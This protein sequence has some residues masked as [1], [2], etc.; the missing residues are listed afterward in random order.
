MRAVVQRGY[1]SSQVWSLDDVEV[2]VPGRGEVLVEVAAAAVDRGTW[3]LMHG[4]PAMVRPVIG[5]RT[6][7]QPV[8][9][10][11]VAGTVTAVG[12]GVTELAVGD[13]VFGMARGSLAP[14]A[15]AKVA[16][17][18]PRP[19]GAPWAEAAAL[20]VSGLTAWQALEAAQVGGGGRLL[21]VGA[22]GGVG[23]LAVQLAV[24]RGLEVVAV[25]SRAKAESVR[26]WGATRVLAHDAA[27]DPHA[28]VA[29]A[30]TGF[31]ALLDVAG[32]LPLATQRRLVTE[33]GTMVFV[34]TET[35]QRITGGFGA[36]VRRSLRMALARQRYVM[37]VSAERGEDL[38]RLAEAYEAG[39]VR[40]HLH[41]VL[42]L[43]QAR[44]AIDLLES[45][46]VTGK[47]AVS[48]AADVSG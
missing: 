25:C 22:S 7:R 12:E 18:A 19:A 6:P 8:P 4:L 47:V 46:R 13:E 30:G 11:D 34:G 29:E 27:D 38:R 36:P 28:W 15:V 40:P 32:G 42:P 20:G 41:A 39:Q 45:G 33:R 44:T 43:E 21:V 5:W 10:L 9:G 2:P 16:K 31:D 17:L 14:Y 35:D 48:V 23:H 1:G 24:A 26:G 3:H 37:L